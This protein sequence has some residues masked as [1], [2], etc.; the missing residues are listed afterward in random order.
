MSDTCSTCKFWGDGNDEHDWT[1]TGVG[2][3][4]CQAVRERW[5][6]QDE[7]SKGLE[8]DDD[9]GSAYAKA[10]ADALR[11]SK[12]YVQDGSEYRADLVTG[13]DFGCVLHQPT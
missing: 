4:R 9:D 7:A 11:A 8:W 12:A 2:F 3:K 5:E 13:P 1:A 6:I 10:R